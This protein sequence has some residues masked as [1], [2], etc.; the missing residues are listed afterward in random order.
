[1]VNSL[2][3]SCAKQRPRCFDFNTAIKIA[4]KKSNF[5]EQLMAFFFSCIIKTTQ[6]YVRYIVLVRSRSVIMC[7]RKNLE[8]DY[9]HD[10]NETCLCNYKKCQ[11]V[12]PS[13]YSINK[14]TI[15][16]NISMKKTWK[17]IKSN[18]GYILQTKSDS[19]LSLK[20][21]QKQCNLS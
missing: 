11:L 21:M 15:S 20:K 1:M 19:L 5:E 4:A 3:I 6:S 9:K 13:G 2:L 7:T 12:D 18:A 14:S 10:K 16:D 17:I 8:S